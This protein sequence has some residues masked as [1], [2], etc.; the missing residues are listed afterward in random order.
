VTRERFIAELD[1]TRRFETGIFA[2]PITFTA[3]DHVGVNVGKMTTLIN[4]K[5]VVVAR[6]PAK[7]AQL[8]Q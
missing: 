7:Q 4:N 1:K 5:E 3:K 8:G 2:E 6:Y